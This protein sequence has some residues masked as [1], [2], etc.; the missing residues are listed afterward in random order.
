MLEKAGFY[1]QVPWRVRVNEK[2]QCSGMT[3]PIS[4]IRYKEWGV[5]IRIKP[6]DNNTCHNV[7]L[8]I[9]VGLKAN[10]VYQKLKTI[11]KSFNRNWRKVENTVPVPTLNGFNG[12]SEIGDDTS[13]DAAEAV[14]QEELLNEEAVEN[15]RLDVQ[16]FLSN[17]DNIKAICLSIHAMETTDYA[18]RK[19]TSQFM[20]SICQNL[21]ISLT[22][23]QGGSMMRSIMN[24]GL[25]RKV[26]EGKYHV[27]YLLT[28]KGKDLIKDDLLPSQPPIASV[29]KEEEVVAVV[30]AGKKQPEPLK[31]NRADL[32]LKIGP[33][34][35]DISHA[36]ARLKEIG[37]ERGEHQKKIEALDKEEQ[38]IC[39]LLESE[40]IERFLADLVDIKLKPK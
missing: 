39:E 40:E 28:R 23:R 3:P 29:A 2:Q 38:E 36:S 34:A 24:R 14:L 20:S 26:H 6:G 15:K 12:V 10:E 11:E 22:G 35:Q 8:I 27:G 9:P 13:L 17:N 33:I 4:V 7:T 5:F 37:V 16:S 1:E 19:D 21:S 31:T 18:S 25:A 30:E 32:I